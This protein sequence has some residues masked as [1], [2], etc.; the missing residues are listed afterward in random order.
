MAS[1]Q[2]IARAV[3]IANEQGLK[4]RRVQVVIVPPATPSA[5]TCFIVV[6]LRRDSTNAT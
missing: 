4:G 3:E 6:Q 2:D 5:E 1:Q